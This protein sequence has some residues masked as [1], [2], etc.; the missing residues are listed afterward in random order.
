ME[1]SQ[2]NPTSTP[3]THPLLLVA[4]ASVIILSL[5]GVAALAGWLPGPG[6]S[7]TSPQTVAL[8]AP[9]LPAAAAVAAQP[10]ITV[11]Q[12]KAQPASKPS[13]REAVSA[14]RAA[15]EPRT[16]PSAV[17][18]APTFVASLPAPPI[19]RECGVVETVNEVAIE[20][21]GSGGGAVAGGVVGG[22]LGNQIGKGATRDI[23]TIIG[24]VGGAF[25]GNHIE[26]SSKESKRYD[27]IVRFEDGSTQT[28]SSE[29]R[30][31]WLSGDRVRLQNGLLT[32]AGGS[33]GSNV[34][35]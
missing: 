14:Q 23:A 12:K 26:K 31:V 11:P 19:C 20:P 24:A 22:I 2:I 16:P 25:A 27:V 35:I 28:F 4:A 8:A 9:P 21:K 33:S 29:S 5:A 15:P 30:P 34:A 32:N 17:S 6:N 13:K 18:P 1:A 7:N 10:P 3:H